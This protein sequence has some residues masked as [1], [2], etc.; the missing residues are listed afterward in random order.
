M[1]VYSLATAIIPDTTVEFTATLIVAGL[2]VVLGILALL[3]IVV[4]VYGMIVSKSQG[5][6]MRKN[7]K[8]ANS[9]PPQLNIVNTPPPAPAKKAAPVSQGISGEV[10]A[11]ISAAVYM[12]EG[13]G[14]VVR[15]VTPVRT[16]TPNP[17]TRRNPWAFAA[18]TENTRPF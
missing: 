9:A 5:A 11:A 12:M 1:D 2:S 4:K 10:I 15:S 8:K 3:I 16:Q 14:A 17:V 7:K 18:I 13:E 6:N